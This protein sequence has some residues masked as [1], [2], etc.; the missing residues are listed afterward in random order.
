MKQNIAVKNDE[1]R[2][3][4]LNRETSHNKLDELTELLVREYLMNNMTAEN[5]GLKTFMTRLEK[6]IIDIALSLTNGSQKNAARILGVK[7]TSLCEKIKKFHLKR[8]KKRI[9]LN[10]DILNMGEEEISKDLFS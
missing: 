7:E 5:T 3:K 9:L 6:R 8:D 10:L 1:N 2:A 4:S